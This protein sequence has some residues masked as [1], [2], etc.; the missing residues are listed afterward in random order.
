MKIGIL[1]QPLYFNY[2]GVLQAYALY[3]A[4]Q[5]MGH[6]VWII[7]R[8]DSYSHGYIYRSLSK[9]KNV[10]KNYFSLLFGKI[11][12]TDFKRKSINLSS[13]QTFVF[14]SERMPN[15]SKELHSDKELLSFVKK[16]NFDAY[17]VGSDQVWRPKYS[18]NIY[19]YFL[20]FSSEQSRKVAYAASFGVDTWEY[21]NEETLV[22]SDLL[23]RFNAVSVREISGIFLCTKY[24]NRSD[25]KFVLDPDR[26]SVV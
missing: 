16:M 25:A 3:N 9:C 26:K 15:R 23:Q 21:T 14:V 6:E 2:G 10:L 7:N 12:Y 17:V 11:K 19:T 4:L 5:K 13:Y 18:P 22:C 1:T 20:D 8:V 24:L